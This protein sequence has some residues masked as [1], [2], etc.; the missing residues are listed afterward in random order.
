MAKEHDVFVRYHQDP[1]RKT[2]T[3]PR[4]GLDLSQADIDAGMR[5]VWEEFQQGRENR[6]GA[7]VAIEGF[8]A[9]DAVERRINHDVMAA[10][11]RRATAANPNLDGH[12][13]PGRS[14]RDAFGHFLSVDYIE[15]LW[16]SSRASLGEAVSDKNIVAGLLLFAALFCPASQREFVIGDME[17]R[18]PSDRKR[19]GS[20]GAKLLI[21]RDIATSA[22]AAIKLL[23]LTALAKIKIWT[24]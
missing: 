8:D 20:L 6:Q 11:R 2:G 21:V 10:A 15:H 3:S 23:A 19:Y 5:A 13:I 4:N 16:R 18:Y 22:P 12:D 9:L 14:L 1:P 7:Y 17:Q 24:G